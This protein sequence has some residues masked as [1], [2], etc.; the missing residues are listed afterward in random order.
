MNSGLLLSILFLTIYQCPK[1]QGANLRLGRSRQPV[2]LVPA[3]LSSQA[4]PS[5]S[6]AVVQAASPVAVQV[7]SPAAVQAASPT[8]GSLDSTLSAPPF[9]IPG[10]ESGVETTSENENE[11][12]DK[13]DDEE[14]AKTSVDSKTDEE[15]P[16]KSGEEQPSESRSEVEPQKAGS[17][18]IASDP[19]VVCHDIDKNWKD[20]EGKSCQDYGDQGICASGATPGVGA[21]AAGHICC[22][23]GGGSLEVNTAMLNSTQVAQMMEGDPVFTDTHKG[24]VCYDMVADWKDSSGQS[25]A[26]YHKQDLCS[27]EGP[28]TPEPEPE[29]SSSSFGFGSIFS[30][31]ALL[32][33]GSTDS[34]NQICCTCGGGRKLKMPGCVGDCGR[35]E[36]KAISQLKEMYQKLAEKMKKEVNK[37]AA[38]ES[39]RVAVDLKQTAEGAL[40]TMKEEREEAVQS[41]FEA[42]EERLATLTDGEENLE[43]TAKE[44]METIGAKAALDY[45][46][47]T[48]LEDLEKE[49]QKK[50]AALLTLKRSTSKSLNSLLQKRDDPIYDAVRASTAPIKGPPGVE[51]AFADAAE[52]VVGNTTGNVTEV[53][54]NPGPP[55]PLPETVSDP[56]T[57]TGM[58][59]ESENLTALG[60]ETGTKWKATE[61][62]FK[63][64]SLKSKFALERVAGKLNEYVEAENSTNSSAIAE[65]EKVVNKANAGEAE[66]ERREH[67]VELEV[68]MAHDL[69]EVSTK[70]EQEEES[71]LESVKKAEETVDKLAQHEKEDLSKDF[72]LLK[73]VEDTVNSA[74]S[75]APSPSF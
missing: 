58:K 11:N 4:A 52:G 45:M 69:S 33:S 50:A 8:E 59:V 14:V 15:Q 3:E 38:A 68:D 41:A 7:A 1:V 9:S 70:R 28:K 20:L 55:E 57:A 66:V 39:A 72:A 19:A 47:S 56:A 12:G 32:G 30:A 63:E 6:P 29:S 5:P 34:A 71:Q 53:L 42:S 25:C 75:P 73:E 74:A 17:G 61:D 67:Q 24:T 46:R 36:D 27:T 31:G 35:A 64:A 60:D 54:S 51:E 44:D 40:K 13:K 23:C 22:S 49:A 37:R 10:L 16:S 18:N 62:E 26:D 65:F 2:T 48:K 21:E 43:K